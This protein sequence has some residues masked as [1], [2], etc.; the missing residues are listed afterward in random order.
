VSTF[1]ERFGHLAVLFLGVLVGDRLRFLE[2]ILAGD[3][4]VAIAAG[5]DFFL[6]VVVDGVF[7]CCFDDA[8]VCDGFPR[9]L[10][11][12]VLAAD[13]SDLV[14]AGFKSWDFLGAK[15]GARGGLSP[16]S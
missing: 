9:L 6:L 12:G 7:F 14:A 3:F 8:G 15:I 1:V 16:L 10:A 13:D 2:L 11:L 5:W 4:G